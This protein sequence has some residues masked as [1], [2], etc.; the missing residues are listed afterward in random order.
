MTLFRLFLFLALL[1]FSFADPSTP[2]TPFVAVR[3]LSFFAERRLLQTS[4]SLTAEDLAASL[5]TANQSS[6]IELDVETI[7]LDTLL[8]IST[9]NLR[10][11]GVLETPTTFLCEGEG[12][13]EIT[14]SK[15]R[16]ENIG[17]ENC[18]GGAVTVINLDAG[19]NPFELDTS[20]K[21]DSV[22]IELNDVYFRNNS[23]GM[24]PQR[25]TAGA[26]TLGPGTSANL[27]KCEF[28]NNS[29]S[30]GGAILVDGSASLLM[31]KCRFEDNTAVI[32][33]GAIAAGL[34]PNYFKREANIMIHESTFL[35]NRD[36]SGAGDPA[37]L[38]LPNGAPLESS[39]FLKFPSPS[40]S[41]GAIFV[42]GYNKV[43]IEKS[44]FEENT[45][46]PAG[47]ALFI[48]DNQ[49]VQLI[50][51]TFTGNTVTSRAEDEM[52]S[53]RTTDLEQGGAVYLAFID[54]HSQ[55]T[56]SQCYF[57]NN[58]AAYGGALHVVTALAGTVKIEHSQFDDNNAVFAGGAMVV[59]NT[60]Q[61]SVLSL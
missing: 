48:Q 35:R 8:T 47:G 36:L 25:S 40:A 52:L 23:E 3:N 4:G 29:A 10:L 51:S 32:A 27:K 50:N 21:F 20:Q 7:T 28:V 24:I 60:V 19:F 33:G 16:L 55:A 15:V 6:T 43:L 34:T 61:V 26:L 1:N 49:N 18:V 12:R 37:G 31:E 39:V 30:T 5:A 56:F 22:D 41:G 38:V 53:D 17:F 45:A 2:K 58:S 13:V 59:R 9:E 57:N 44:I 14:A 42:S 46:V 11:E 54:V